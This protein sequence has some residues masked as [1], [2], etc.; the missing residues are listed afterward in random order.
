MFDK[1]V[2]LGGYTARL[3]FLGGRLVGTLHGHHGWDDH[4]CFPEVSTADPRFDPG[5]ARGFR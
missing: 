5:W 2:S 4:S 1:E 3:A